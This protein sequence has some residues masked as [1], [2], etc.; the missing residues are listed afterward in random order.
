[1]S[2][3][4]GVGVGDQV[5]P[6]F[7]QPGPERGRVVDDPVVDDG[8]VALG[9]DVRMRVDV[10]RRPVRRPAGV[11]DADLAGEPLG[12]PVGQVAHPSGLLRHP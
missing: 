8:H 4:L 12:Q 3:H 2:Q 6:R 5:D 7:R 1:V 11:P 9:V 10:V